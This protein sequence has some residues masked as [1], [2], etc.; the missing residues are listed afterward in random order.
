[1][2]KNKQDILTNEQDIRETAQEIAEVRKTGRA[3]MF[4]IEA[5]VYELYHLGHT[6]TAEY[7]QDNRKDYVDRLLELSGKY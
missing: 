1:M 5:V 3:N 7:I 2:L 4:D 6:F